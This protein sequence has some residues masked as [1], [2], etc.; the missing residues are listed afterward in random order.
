LPGNVRARFHNDPQELLEF[1]SDE[2][3]R[4][5]AEK[6]GIAIP[7]VV[8]KPVEVA[9]GAAPAGPLPPPKEVVTS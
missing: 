4:A 7:K 6:L 9:P 3:N 2:K 1:C 8:V 5:E